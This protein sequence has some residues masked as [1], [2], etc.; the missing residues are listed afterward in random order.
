M[1][2]SMNFTTRESGNR[3]WSLPDMKTNLSPSKI[4]MKLLHSFSWYEILWCMQGGDSILINLRYNGWELILISPESKPIKYSRYLWTR[5]I[6]KWR[7][8][9][10]LSTSRCYQRLPFKRRLRNRPYHVVEKLLHRILVQVEAPKIAS[11]RSYRI[12]R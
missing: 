4:L 3:S 1:I 11:V 6:G 12:R 10:K 7:N 8:L 9:I 5:T 2:F